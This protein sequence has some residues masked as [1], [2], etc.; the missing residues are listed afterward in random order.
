MLHP[1]V[2][3]IPT[4]MYPLCRPFLHFL[5][6][7]EHFQ[8]LLYPCIGSEAIIVVVWMP[9]HLRK[10]HALPCLDDW[11]TQASSAQTEV[12]ELV[13]LL[14]HLF[15]IT[16]RRVNQ[17]PSAIIPAGSSCNRV[18]GKDWQGSFLAALIMKSDAYLV[19]QVFWHLCFVIFTVLVYW[20]KK[21]N[22]P[23]LHFPLAQNC[24]W[25][26]TGQYQPN[27]G[28]PTLLKIVAGPL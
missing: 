10:L 6:H 15:I 27:F 28:C 9:F 22:W 20:A 24:T 13:E 4:C 17:S 2:L 16:L 18:P 25:R 8:V 1:Y 12:W 14:P 5:L 21:H 26:C 23:L 19:K 11:L 7:Q 3:A